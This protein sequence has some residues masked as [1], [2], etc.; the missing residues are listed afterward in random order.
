MSKLAIVSPNKY[1]YSETFIHGHVREL[2]F[3]KFLLHGGYLPTAVSD[4]LEGPDQSLAYAPWW[5]RKPSEEDALK[6]GLRRFLM[7]EKIGI[8]LAEYGPTGVAV[9]ETCR[10]LDLPLVVH[11][12]GYDAYRQDILGEQGQQYPQLFNLA[13]ALVV[14]SEDMRRQI[15]GL[16]APAEKVHLIPYGVDPLMFTQTDVA[17]N[18]QLLVGIGRFTAKKAPQLTIKAF[19]RIAEEHP[20]AQLHLAGEGNL[21]EE[22][23]TL[24]AEMGLVDRILFPG[25]LSPEAVANLLSRAR[26]FVQH[27]IRPEDGDS[28][29]LPLAVLEAM[30]TGLPVVATRHA[31]IPDAVRDGKEGLLCSE[32]DVAAMAENM[33]KILGDAG[34]AAQLGGNG[35]ERVQTYFT[36]ERYLGDLAKL[37]A[38]LL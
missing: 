26:G 5:Q 3:Q 14:V 33:G 22:C 19:A 17:A 25:R 35:Q 36:R 8:L 11:F 21:L 37:L 9:M 4:S 30:A 18:P 38:S 6:T 28:E 34:Y 1:K 20:D 15:I 31:G 2:P 13:S 23:Q 24:V 7:R 27:S 10:D 12:H 16:G 32:K 29:G